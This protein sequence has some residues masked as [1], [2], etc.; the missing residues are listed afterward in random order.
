LLFERNP[1]FLYIKQKTCEMKKLLS[2][3]IVIMIC[4][5]LYAQSN[6][7]AA[8]TSTYEVMP[9]FIGGTRAMFSYLNKNINYP[10]SALDTYCMGKVLVRFVVGTDGMVSVDSLNTSNLVFYK[11]KAK[12]EAKAKAVEDL[13]TEVTRLFTLMPAWKPAMQ[14]GKPVKVAFTIPYNL[15][16][17]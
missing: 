3:L 14:G 17:E 11:K 16:F 15:Y 10:K 8:D 1:V 4:Q 12:E 6:M 13:K 2:L 7:M 9:E 5:D